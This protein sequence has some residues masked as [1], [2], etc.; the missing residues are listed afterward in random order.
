MEHSFLVSKADITQAVKELTSASIP[1][2]VLPSKDGDE[3]DFYIVQ[4]CTHLDA[5]SR[6]ISLD[7]APGVPAKFDEICG[8]YAKT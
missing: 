5:G 1:I 7:L 3:K 8:R 4:L 6:S 2:K